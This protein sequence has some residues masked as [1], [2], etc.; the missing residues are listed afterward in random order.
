M[1]PYWNKAPLVEMGESPLTICGFGTPVNK[2]VN[3]PLT[4]VAVYFPWVRRATA[5]S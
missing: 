2:V 1:G 5:E 3:R 4:A